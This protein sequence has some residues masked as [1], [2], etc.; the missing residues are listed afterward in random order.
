M[1]VQPFDNLAGSR[2][3]CPGIETGRENEKE[4]GNE[5]KK[6]SRVGG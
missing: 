3:H 2:E 1:N 6:V 5:N 4:S